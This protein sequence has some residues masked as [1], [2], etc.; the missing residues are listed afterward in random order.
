MDTLKDTLGNLDPE[1]PAKVLL[2][3]TEPLVMPH[4]AANA[5]VAETLLDDGHEVVTT[6]CRGGL[7]SCI[8]M[9][10]VL[11]MMTLNV[12]V[13]STMLSEGKATQHLALPQSTE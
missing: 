9:D 8:G 5:F 3:T 13:L 2:F 12:Q 7:T 6:T 11:P 10:S 1:R 4:Y